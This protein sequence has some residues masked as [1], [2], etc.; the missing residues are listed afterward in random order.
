MNGV[1]L[2]SNFEIAIK[3]TIGNADLERKQ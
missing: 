2:W 1:E 3:E